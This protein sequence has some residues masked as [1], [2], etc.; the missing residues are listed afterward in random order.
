M[1]DLILSSAAE[2]DYAEAFAWYAA[3]S[4]EAAGHYDAALDDALAT[5]ASDPERCPLCDQ[6]HRF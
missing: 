2:E 5:S 4:V 1:S 3:H 6:R